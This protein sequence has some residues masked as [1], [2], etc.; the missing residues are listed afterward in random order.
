VSKRT[1]SGLTEL[2]VLTAAKTVANT[3]LRW[4]GPFLP[5]LERAFATSIG[6]LTSI[7]AIAELTGLTTTLT[8]R[9][10]DR[11]HQRRIFVA[12]LW[13][14]AASSVIATI[15]SVLWFAVAVALLVV[16]VSNLTVAGLAWISGKV[17]YESRGRSIGIFEMSWALALLIG[18]P[19]IALQIN[20]FGWRGPFVAL[21]IAAT[22]AA[23]AVPRFVA[24]DLPASRAPSRTERNASPA[25]GLPRSAWAPLLASALSAAAGLSIFVVSG[26][27]LSDRHGVSTAGLGL[28]ATGFGALELFSSLS[29]A[30]WADRIGKRRSVAIGLIVLGLGLA[31]TAISGDSL[32]LA[33]CGLTVFL[34]GFEYAFVTS[35]SLVSEAAPLTRGR[36]LGLGNGLGT[37]ARASAVF[38][39]GQLYEATGLGGPLVLSALIASAAFLAVLL[40]RPEVSRDARPAPI[41]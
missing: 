16:G 33:V 39:S 11:G 1:R 21:A 10:L 31:T 25:V 4:L 20:L 2:A 22:I 41:L 38:A 27:W 37:L 17:P 19:L 40:S 34:A 6:T 35:L 12:G 3:A 32:V 24:A 29:S 26:A 30:A 9:V 18:A 15:G 13:A 36:A 5:T 23:L 7:I 28:V 14:V 8:G